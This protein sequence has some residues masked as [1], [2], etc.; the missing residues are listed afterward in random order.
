MKHFNKCR[1]L[2]VAMCAAITLRAVAANEELPV[3]DCAKMMNELNRK[4]EKDEKYKALKDALRGSDGRCEANMMAGIDREFARRAAAVSTKNNAKDC[5]ASLCI[6]TYQR[7]GALFEQYKAQLLKGCELAAGAAKACTAPGLPA[8]DAERFRCISRELRKGA[9]AEKEAGGLITRAKEEAEN[10]RKLASEASSTYVKDKAAIRPFESREELQTARVI[11]GD[12]LET[13]R[14]VLFEQLKAMDAAGTRSTVTAATLPVSAENG[15]APNL[16]AYYN[17]ADNLARE[18]RIAAAAATGFRDFAKEEA[19]YRRDS[20]RTLISMAEENERRANGLPPSTI[21]PSPQTPRNTDGA[22]MLPGLGTTAGLAS[23]ATGLTNSLNQQAGA[24]AAAPASGLSQLA[25]AAQALSGIGSGAKEAEVTKFKGGG[26]NLGKVENPP[27]DGVPE[28]P[29]GR[30]QLAA[31]ST[32][33]DGAFVSG[34]GDLPPI[35]GAGQTGRSLASSAKTGKVGGGGA[36][37]SANSKKRKGSAE[38]TAC[39][40]DKECMAAMGV[41]TAQ[42]N[43]A[44][45]LGIP[46]TGSSD[47]GLGSLASLDNLFGPLP[48]DQPGITPAG[49]TPL[50]GNL[51]LGLGASDDFSAPVSGVQAAVE[52]APANSRSLFVRV[53]EVHE[54]ALKRGSVS[55]FH[56]RL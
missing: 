12:K 54:K 20:E 38:T 51:G 18:Q 15:G 39:G 17:N 26:S 30:E 28:N 8:G 14:P 56:K 32:G 22:S 50:F 3:V 7:V 34:N 29:Q 33:G 19:D 35:D 6:A 24:S 43:K 2:L 46:V 16:R 52:L 9:A 40:S 41:E 5:A 49:A 42:F 31:V 48:G 25:S 1:M 13:D 27:K 45:S 37:V 10:F 36:D 53:K 21:I 4:V 23:A 55:L 11:R 44:G 47:T